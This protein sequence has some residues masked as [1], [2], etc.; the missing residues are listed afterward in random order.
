MQPCYSQLRHAFGEMPVR[1][2]HKK[3]K[4]TISAAI[5]GALAVPTTPITEEAESYGA[6]R[7]HGNQECYSD[8]GQLLL[9]HGRDLPL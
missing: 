3:A 7:G 1:A 4:K 2:H 6:R 8:A 9:K 5:Q